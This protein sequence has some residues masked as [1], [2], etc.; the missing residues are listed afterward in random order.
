M[1]NK[2]KNE[3]AYIYNK[4]W[5]YGEMSSH[6][7]LYINRRE[8]GRQMDIVSFA[9]SSFSRQW[10]LLNRLLS[11]RVIKSFS[12]A[13]GFMGNVLTTIYDKTLLKHSAT[14]PYYLLIT[15]TF[16]AT[17][18][19]ILVALETFTFQVDQV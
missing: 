19:P 8:G 15:L 4:F 14:C 17:H 10:S 11:S 2:V 7:V 9:H 3:A 18:M 5:C 6:C 1:Q 12:S 16:S 13:L